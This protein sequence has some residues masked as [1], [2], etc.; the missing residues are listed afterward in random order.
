MNEPIFG[1]F[2][3]RYKR[4]LVDVRLEDGKTITA[5]CTNTGSLRSCLIENAPVVIT[6]SDNKKR[7]TQYTWEMI[8]AGETWVGVNTL[9]ANKLGYLILKHRL[10]QNFSQVKN[11]KREITFQNS[12]LDLYCEQGKEKIFIE[13]KNV[14]YR[15]GKF[16]LFPDAKTKR[17]QKHLKAL[18]MA[19][20]MGYRASLFFIIQRSD[21]EFFAPA[22][23]IDQDYAE[24]L[25]LAFINGVEIYP[26]Q[27]D[28]QPY[29]FMFKRILDF[30]FK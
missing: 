19:K 11:I 14:T 26:I 21:T 1:R 13:V 7:K 27:F 12:R 5:H 8:K 24:L 28:I 2:I 6:K 23:D 9:N 20:E 30:K 18:M 29:G 15:E 3:K 16:A 4:F 10:L 17:G 22:H 25:Q